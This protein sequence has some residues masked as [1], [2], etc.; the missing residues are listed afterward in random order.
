MAIS[1]VQARNASAMMCH[2]VLVECRLLR[3]RSQVTSLVAL[4]LAGAVLV[5]ASPAA[6]DSPRQNAKVEAGRRLFFDVRLSEPPGTSCASCHDPAHAFSGDNGS[7]LAV[8]RGS[9]PDVRGTRNAPTLMYLATSPGPGF[10]EKEGK[11]VPS[12]GFFWD[13]RARTLSEQALGPLFTAHEMNNRD[14]T[15]LAT[16]VAASDAA[17]WLRLAFGEEV[18][19]KP[20]R[21]LSAMADSL[22]AFEQSPDFAPFSSKF[23]AVVRGLARFSEQEQR[24]QTLFTIAQKGNC[25]ACHTLNSDS[26]DPRDSLFTDFGFHALGVPRNVDIARRDTPDLGYCDALPETTPGRSRW[27]GWFKTPT[28]RNVALTAPYMHNGKFAT[29]REA[30][31][32]YATRDTH[33]ERWYP[34]AEKFDDL[35]AHLR[36]NVD[37]DTRPYHRR[38]GQR[39]ALSDEDIDDIVAFLKTLTDGYVP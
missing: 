23:D 6:A 37:L 1:S 17:P 30:V 24:G 35:P 16:K 14:A 15:T 20:D 26:R 31:A 7:G 5:L 13:G 21:A 25:A 4:V 28:L 9:R 18:F 32:F 34:N 29:L 8:P 11:P 38:P 39:P 33:P 3:M 22:A 27:C 19:A 12:G 10:S 36:A 2:L